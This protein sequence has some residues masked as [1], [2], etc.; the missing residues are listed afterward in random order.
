MSPGLLEALAPTGWPVVGVALARV[1]GLMMSAP[2]FAMAGTP[3]PVRVAVTLL[4]ALALAPQVP[5]FVAPETLPALSLAL[6]VDFLIGLV[7]G[8]VAGVFING[9][10][11]AGEIVSLQM[12]LSTGPILNPMT[13]DGVPGIGQLLSLLAVVIYLA[14]DGHIHLLRG[15]ADS[16]QALPPGGALSVAALPDLAARFLGT[17]FSVAVRAAAPALVALFLVNLAVAITG[18]AVP[19]FP[20]MMVIFPVTITA[21][22]VLLTLA[23]PTTAAAVAGWMGGLPALVSSVTAALVVR[24]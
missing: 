20:A 9:L 14:L 15:L 6:G 18:R 8:L 24:S 10:A 2:L 11:L 3:H 12:G 7:I 16:F 21:G 4:L 1:S 22:V 5:P 13:D 23:I 19:Q 17:V